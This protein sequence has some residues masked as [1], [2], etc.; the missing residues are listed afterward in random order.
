MTEKN[1]TLIRS[2]RYV[3]GGVTEV[4]PTALEWWE[5]IVIANADDD[6]AYVVQKQFVGRLDLISALFLDNSKIWWVIAQYNN[7][8]DPYSEIKEGL[9]LYIPSKSRAEAMLNG[10]LGGVDSTREAPITILP[11][12]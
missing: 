10:S 2:S 6:T 9:I 8:L 12:V 4:T 5:R 11:L 1:S 7:I 3:S